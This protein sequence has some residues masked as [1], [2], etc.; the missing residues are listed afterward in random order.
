VVR[1]HPAVPAK[2]LQPLKIKG[3]ISAPTSPYAPC[4]FQAGPKIFLWTASAGYASI[5][6][7]PHQGGVLMNLA[8][9]ATSA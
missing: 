1:V 2:P 9:L 3:T 7:H 5:G 8:A 6:P 4:R